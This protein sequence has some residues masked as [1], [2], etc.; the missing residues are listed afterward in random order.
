MENKKKLPKNCVCVGKSV[1]LHPLRKKAIKSSLKKLHKT[2]E[3]VQEAKLS[4][5]NYFFCI[6]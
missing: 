5:E 4:A 6:G 1:P 3:V 2:E